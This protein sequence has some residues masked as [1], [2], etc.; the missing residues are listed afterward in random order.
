MGEIP[1][2]LPADAL[3]YVTQAQQAY[4]QTLG[5]WI[6]DNAGLLD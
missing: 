1:E 5:V 3:G 2:R 4:D 6:A